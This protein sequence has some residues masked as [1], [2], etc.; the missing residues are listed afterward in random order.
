M[1]DLIISNGAIIVWVLTAVEL[2]LILAS[3]KIDRKTMNILAAAECFGLFVDGLVMAVGSLIGEGSLLQGI[4]QVRYI[5]HGLL[6]PLLIPMAFYA[7]GM[8]RKISK[9]ILWCVT[10]VAIAL[11]LIGGI[12]TKTEPVSMAGVLRYASSD[13]TPAFADKMANMFSVGGVIPLIVVGIA[14]WVKH[15]SPFVFLSGIL[16]FAFAAIA[17]ATGNVDLIF[18]VSMFGEALMMFFYVLELKR[19]KKIGA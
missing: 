8:K 6:V 11:G 16:M 2:L 15:K 5:L 19:V 1:R 17:P 4:S 7:F 3:I 9:T 10:G 14:H 12:L 13:A 18:I